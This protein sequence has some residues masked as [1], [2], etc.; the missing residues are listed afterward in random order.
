V[1][2]PAAQTASETAAPTLPMEV[3]LPAAPTAPAARTIPVE[4]MLPAAPFA[5]VPAAP[6]L[7]I[8]ATLSAPT[9]CA[10]AARTL[11]MEVT[12]AVPTASEPAASMLIEPAAPAPAPAPPVPPPP[13]GS[14][15][16]CKLPGFPWWPAKLLSHVSET[17]VKIRFFE[18]CVALVVPCA[19]TSVVKFEDRLGL[20]D[21]DA[22][23]KQVKKPSLRK[24]LL[25]AVAQAKAPGAVAMARAEADA[26]VT[27]AK[28]AAELALAWKLEGH[29]NLGRR[30]ARKFGKSMAYGTIT[31]W[32]PPEEAEESTLFHID[33][34]DGAPTKTKPRPSLT[35]ARPPF[36]SRARHPNKAR[37]QRKPFCAAD[38]KVTQILK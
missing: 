32:A 36:E 27:V 15:V 19:P 7:P 11:P 30:V 24:Q 28:A 31:R 17:T 35:Q 23:K 12:P 3:T 14:L 26:E 21:E 38:S 20:C 10:P 16:W 4:V 2:L 5:S 8:E 18:T 34:D 22:I 13:V 1:T 9:A 29:A 33:H 6:T 25:L 37:L